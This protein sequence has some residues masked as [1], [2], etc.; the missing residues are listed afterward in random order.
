[1]IKFHLTNDFYDIFIF[2]YNLFET[3]LV[4]KVCLIEYQKRFDNT[5]FHEIIRYNLIVKG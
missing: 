1:M 3:T 2:L 4:I 5:C